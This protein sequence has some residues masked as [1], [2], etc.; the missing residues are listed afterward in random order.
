MTGTDHIIARWR[1]INTRQRQ[2]LE[3]E[4]QHPDSALTSGSKSAV[5]EPD[6]FT[7]FLPFLKAAMVSH[8]SEQQNA[9]H[10]ANGSVAH[11]RKHSGTKAQEH[12][13]TTKQRSQL[14]LACTPACAPSSAR[15]EHDSNINIG[16]AS[17]DQTRR[18]SI[19]ICQAFT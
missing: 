1:R 13:Y 18:N 5:T 3:A 9:M 17:S 10:Q 11:K 16:C 7:A 2:Q 6:A 12:S 19:H 15:S 14:A 8:C 4:A